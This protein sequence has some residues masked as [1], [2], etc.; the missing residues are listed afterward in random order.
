VVMLVGGPAPGAVHS[1]HRQGRSDLLPL[2]RVWSNETIISIRRYLR[3]T[4]D[5]ARGV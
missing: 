1:I 5:V 2:P 4:P 3:I